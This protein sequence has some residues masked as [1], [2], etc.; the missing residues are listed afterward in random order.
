MRCP[1][2]NFGETK[3]IETRVQEGALTGKLNSNIAQLT[4]KAKHKWEDKQVIDQ[5]TTI[6]K[7]DDKELNE[8]LA[9]DIADIS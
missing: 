1:Y 4:L 6:E 3:V 5:R 8:E 7:K 2:C 9:K